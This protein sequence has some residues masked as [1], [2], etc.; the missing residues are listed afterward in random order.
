M[1]VLSSTGA[2]TV[3]VS[4]IR[5]FG[6]PCFSAPLCQ[7]NLPPPRITRLEQLRP[8]KTV[9]AK[10]TVIAAQ[11]APTDQKPDLIEESKG[12]G[13]DH[14]LGRSVPTVA[15]GELRASARCGSPCA[16]ALDRQ[17]GFSR[18]DPGP[19]IS[20]VASMASRMSTGKNGRNPPKRALRVFCA[21]FRHHAW[22][23]SVR[24]ALGVSS[25]SMGNDSGGS[26]KPGRST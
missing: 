22:R 10:T 18:T 2:L 8:D 19:M 16:E 3:S 15:I 20:G 1:H 26:R 25:S 14:A 12:K 9:C 11:F 5:E 4:I 6:M 17:R 21:S 7:Q 24:Q 23:P 13:P